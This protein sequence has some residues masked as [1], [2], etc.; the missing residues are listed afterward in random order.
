MSRDLLDD[1]FEMVHQRENFNK[2]FKKI[3]ILWAF[4]TKSRRSITQAS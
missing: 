1:E 4:N 3:E 2:R